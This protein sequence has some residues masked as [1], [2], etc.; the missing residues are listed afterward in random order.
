M[1]DM[2]AQAARGIHI[3]HVGSHRGS[4]RAGIDRDFEGEAARPALGVGRV[5]H[6][7]WRSW[8][9]VAGAAPGAS[10]DLAAMRSR[11]ARRCGLA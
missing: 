5:E 7:P 3:E 11:R 1:L 2:A 9:A 10:C 6:G 4:D 8:A